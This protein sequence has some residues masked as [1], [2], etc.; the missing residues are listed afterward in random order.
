MSLWFVLGL[1]TVAAI[2]AV[3]WPL[4][5][6]QARPRAGQDIAVY[7]DQL[8]EISRD[9]SAGMILASEAET[10]RIEISR[11]L[12][13]A[14]KSGEHS[15][16]ASRPGIRRTV[17]V[18]ALAGL[19]LLAGALYLRHG[20]P[21][22]GDFALA[23]RS[24]P[25]AGS[26]SLETLVAQVE[27]HLE[28]NPADG[29]GWEVLGPVL[30]KLGRVDDAVRAHRNSLAYNGE[31]A[32]RRSDLGEA[33]AAAAGGIVTAQSKL[34]FERA[35]SLDPQEAKA[36]YFIAV[37]AG[38]DGQPEQAAAI[39]RDMLKT[40]PENAPWRGL[41]ERALA[42]GGSVGPELPNETIAAANDMTKEQRGEL[43]GGMVDR[44]AARLKINGDDVEGWLRLVRAYMVLGEPDKAKQ[45]IADAR[46]ATANDSE[47]L[48]ALND[49]LS[50][51]G[52]DG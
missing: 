24:P 48:R 26:A 12:L 33:I 52:I 49:A 20:S 11:R 50:R 6:S 14:A 29:R 32:A 40:A 43:I 34:E 38:Q 42:E 35:L 1:M 4:G 9:Q 25:Q 7:Q 10:A 39:W 23:S 30:F 44:L 5:R 41:V 2:F 51:I 13:A 16:T 19:P 8:S 17:A 31:T 36:R 27:S 18:F 46:Q 28:K 22:L 21:G 15:V 47:R 37:A 3:I 45:A